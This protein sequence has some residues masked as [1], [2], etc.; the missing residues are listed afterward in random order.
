MAVADDEADEVP[1]AQALSGERL[2]Y[3]AGLRDQQRPIT[4][5]PSPARQANDEHGRYRPTAALVRAANVAL[6]LRMPLLL[7]GEPGVGKSEFV[8][9]L[10]RDLFGKDAPPPIEHAVT[11]NADK[12]SLLY[13]Y[14]ELARLRAAYET[15]DSLGAEVARLRTQADDPA[16]QAVVP[17]PPIPSARP[18]TAYIAFVGLGLAILRAGGSLS[19]LENIEAKGAGAPDRALLTFGNLVPP[20][21]LSEQGE[22]PILL[23][24]EIDKAPRDLP[25]DIL[26]EIEKMRFD[27]PEL[28]VRV[29]LDP[30]K[31]RNWPIV[32]ITS[33]AERTL[34]DAF[35]RRCVYHHIAWP[36][37]AA[38][39]AIV[40]ERLGDLAL[41]SGTHPQVTE[42][43]LLRDALHVMARLRGMDE[44]AKKPATAEFL[45]WLRLLADGARMGL[46]T[47]GF[48]GQPRAQL[49]G[50]LA[51]LLKT[52]DDL[53]LGQ[54]ALVEWLAT[55]TS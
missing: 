34:P 33:N 9:A 27:I 54:Q 30:G 51:V 50:S 43:P 42:T 37:R 15:K 45:A 3:A 21:T 6:M 53:A 32:I 16:A 52:E 4:D 25:N 47:A 31:R 12:A 26:T 39:R 20:D 17:P 13:R 2:F 35:L 5:L 24:D 22:T 40:A 38:L 46:R 14:D 23:L 55:Q 11:S 18:D 1:L 19:K 48:A 29:A 10:A 36:G 28:G 49:L 8:H 41:L 44:L 7:T